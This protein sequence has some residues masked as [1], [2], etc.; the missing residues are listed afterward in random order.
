[1]IAL[2]PQ[3]CRD[4]SLATAHVCQTAALTTAHGPRFAG[5]ADWPFALNPQQ[6]ID[7]SALMAHVWLLELTA[8]QAPKFPGKRSKKP[9]PASFHRRSSTS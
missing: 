2:L 3:Q 9:L 7:P 8:A 5:T 1:M 6:S 4:E